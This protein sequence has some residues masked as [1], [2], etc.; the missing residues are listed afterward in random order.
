MYRFSQ[1]QCYQ[2]DQDNRPP[3]K[4]EEKSKWGVIASVGMG[5]T[6]LLG[7]AKYVLVAMKLTKAAPLLSSKF[8]LVHACLP[9]SL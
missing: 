3:P 7:K 4:K 2:S 6:F 9:R 8:A 1:L 5:A